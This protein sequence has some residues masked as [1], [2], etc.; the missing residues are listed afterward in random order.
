MED[1]TPLTRGLVCFETDTY[2]ARGTLTADGTYRVSSEKANDGIPPGTY[3]VYIFGA[4][5]PVEDS[6]GRMRDARAVPLV[7]VKYTNPDTSEI[8][9]E[10]DAKTKQFDFQVEKPK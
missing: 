1:G 8:T 5:A 7:A 4:E 10:I 3:K 6:E 2:R 9:V